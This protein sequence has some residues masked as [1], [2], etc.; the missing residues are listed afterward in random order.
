MRAAFARTLA[1]LAEQDERIV[2]LTGDLG[3]MALEPFSDK[4]P[5]RFFNVGVAEQ[6]MVGLATGLAEAGFIPWVYSIVTFATL[7]PFE[8]IRNGPIQQ[9]LPVRVVGVGGG[10]EYGQNGLSHYGLEDIGVMRTQPGITIVAPSDSAQTKTAIQA[11]WD[12]PG[13]IYYRLGKDDKIVV[14]GLDGRFDLGQC[15]QLGEGKDLLLVTTGNMAPEVVKAADELRNQG[16]DCTIALVSSFHPSPTD[17]LAGKIAGFKTVLSIESH[18]VTGGLGSFVAE[19][20]AERGLNS[21]LIRCGIKQTPNGVTGSQAYLY[22]QYGLSA[23]ALVKL[24]LNTVRGE[25]SK[26]DAV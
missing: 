24:A 12:L 26:G 4:F 1:E 23:S 15:Q 18:Y 8:F 10:V 6:N 14:P 25:T 17:D 3:Y 21:R 13:P 16:V 5:E 7:R 22:E 19:V 20:I 2:L 9:R 11:T